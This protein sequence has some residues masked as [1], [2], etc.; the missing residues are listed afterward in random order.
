MS[1]ALDL[2]ANYVSRPELAKALKKHPRTLWDWDQ[3]GIGPAV[4]YVGE[5]PY[6]HVDAVRAYLKS[7]ERPM[8]RE[9]RRRRT[10]E[11]AA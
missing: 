3:K 1:A 8:P 5:T 11:V 10:N 2:L 4:T 6:Y 7:R 9:S